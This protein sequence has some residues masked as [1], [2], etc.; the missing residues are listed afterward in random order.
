[1]IFARNGIF[2]DRAR[3]ENGTENL[4]VL[5]APLVRNPM[6]VATMNQFDPSRLTSTSSARRC[7]LFLLSVDNRFPE[8]V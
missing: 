3:F 2:L 4:P 7:F 6:P 8:N 5:F 1:M